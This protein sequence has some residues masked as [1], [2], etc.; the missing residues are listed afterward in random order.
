MLTLAARR[1]RGLSLVEIVVV[2]AI[3]SM[4]VMMAAP[5]FSTWVI[6]SRIRGTAEAMQFGLQFAKAEAVARNTRVR[7]QLTDTLDNACV[8]SLNGLNWVVNL[9]PNAA[10]DQVEGNCGTP[11]NDGAP[12]FILQTRP[13]ATSGTT[14]VVA[15]A[16]SIV[17][18]GLGRQVPPAG[19]AAANLTI[20]I[21]NP[22]AGTCVAAGGELTCLNVVVT[23]AG[24]IRMCNPAF[25]ANDPQGC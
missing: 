8:A 4:L 22:N 1:Q 9:D 5:T 23:P 17:F 24:Q 10:P 18:N 19:V 14:Q 11:A 6:N 13:G 25:P 20:A 12:P 2:L 16:T 7:F 15:S 3:V 21:S